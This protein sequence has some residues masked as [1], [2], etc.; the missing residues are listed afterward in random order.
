MKEEQVCR[1]LVHSCHFKRTGCIKIGLIKYFAKVSFSPKVFL[2]VTLDEKSEKC[3]MHF[4]FIQFSPIP[5]NKIP[6]FYVGDL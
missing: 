2:D 5:L 6:L 3:L 1:K 4:N